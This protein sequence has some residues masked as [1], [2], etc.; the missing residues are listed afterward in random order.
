MFIWEVF[1]SL[2]FLKDRY[3]GYS[4][5]GWQIFH[6]VLRNIYNSTEYN[7]Q[8]SYW[9]LYLQNLIG[10]CLYFLFAKLLFSSIFIFEFALYFLNVLFS[11]AWPSLWVSLDFCQVI[12]IPYFFH[13]PFWRFIFFIWLGHFLLFLCILCNFVLVPVLIRKQYTFPIFMD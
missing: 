11:L 4:I 9:I 2:L 10:S 6:S 13:V 3:A 7:F 12:H 1:I 5:L 8:F